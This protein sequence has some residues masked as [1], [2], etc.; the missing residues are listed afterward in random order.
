[1]DEELAPLVDEA[2]RL[3]GQMQAALEAIDLD[4]DEEFPLPE[5]EVEGDREPPFFHTGRDYMTKLAIYRDHRNNGR[6]GA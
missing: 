3:R 2:Q 5:P 6:G 1:M 4:P